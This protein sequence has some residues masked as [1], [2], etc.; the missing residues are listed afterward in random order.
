MNFKFN[1]AYHTSIL[2]FIFELFYLSLTQYL[3]Y[4]EVG[5]QWLEWSLPKGWLHFRKGK[6]NHVLYTCIA[7]SIKLSIGASTA[8]LRATMHIRTSGL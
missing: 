4:N 8:A 3:L 6:Y 7:V 2:L 5:L 1:E